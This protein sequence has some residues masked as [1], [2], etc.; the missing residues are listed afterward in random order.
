MKFNWKQTLGVIAVASSMVFTHASAASA[1]TTE[2]IP[3]WASAEIASWKDLGLLKGNENGLILP[4][5]G[6]KKTEFVALINRIFQ[7][8]EE[9]SQTY[10]DV[11]K[12]AWYAPEISKAVASGAIIGSGGG[13]IDPLEILTREKAALILSRVF[14]VAGSG[15]ANAP[16]SDDTAISAWAKEAIYAMKEAGYVEGTPQG[17]FQP[18]NAL[19]RAEAVKMINNAMGILVADGSGHSGLSGSN[20]IV[21]TAGST[22]TNL[23][24]SGNL[25]ITPGV[26]EGDLSLVHATI[27]GVVYI[28]GGGIHSITLTD[29]TLNR[30]V[31]NKPSAPVRVLLKGTTAAINVEV[32]SGA[33]IVNESDKAVGTV[34]VLETGQKAVS[35][36]GNVSELNVNGKT[37][38]TLAGGQ[39][40]TF[41]VSAKAGGSGIKLNKGAIVKRMAFNGAANV[42]GEGIISEALVN[43]EGVSLTAKPDKLTIHASKVTIGGQNYDSS[44]NLIPSATST[45]AGAGTN[46]GTASPSPTPTPTPGATSSPSPGTGSPTPT[47]TPSP[48]P[49]PGTGTPTPTPVDPGP[50][51][52]E[53]Y[54]YAE[55]LSSFSSLG[56]EGLA[57]QYLA[58]LQDPSYTPSI[59]NA[60][61]EMPD[62][63]NAITF[64]NYQFTLKPSIFA[65]LRGV[66]T[67]VLDSTRTYLWIGTD[68]GVTRINLLT[69]EMTG[70]TAEGKQL[71]DD[72]VLLLISDGGKGV[73][74]ITLTGVSHIYQ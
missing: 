25:Y 33:Q 58:F 30:I 50:K 14:N 41:N 32:A 40:G 73:F 54:T 10:T 12:A 64:V 6:I 4:N 61:V 63:V 16:F 56:A 46:G 69:N 22:L 13:K 18:K 53:R 48:T 34:N 1:E 44:G 24:L 42:T 23:N 68:S 2:K 67:S 3:V 5:E 70:Y 7:F 9:S 39:I 52:T 36:S 20:L 26:G 72:K 27:G 62:M 19:T 65:S 45:P 37:D 8:S 57:K 31:I 60:G 38:F 21:N 55:A 49:S 74:A 66:N 71:Y 11:P 51:V 35:I 28:N 15:N 43:V 59:A 17:A 47:P 29:S